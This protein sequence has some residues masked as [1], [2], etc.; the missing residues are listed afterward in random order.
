M[1]Q[2]K[3]VSCQMELCLVAGWLL[4]LAPQHWELVRLTS[5]TPGHWRDQLL[6]LLDLLHNVFFSVQWKFSQYQWKS[7]IFSNIFQ[8]DMIWDC[9]RIGW[10]EL[11]NRNNNKPHKYNICNRNYNWWLER[12][13]VRV[14]VWSHQLTGQTTFV[15]IVMSRR[16]LINM[17]A[18]GRHR[19]Q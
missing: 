8:P 11:N 14:V 1:N 19:D 18:G 9:D 3:P 12:R 17:R 6:Q 15:F 13:T 7:S 2:N 5:N 10:T 16:M 4:L